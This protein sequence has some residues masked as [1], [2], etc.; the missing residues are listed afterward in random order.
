MKYTFEEEDGTLSEIEYIQ[1]VISEKEQNDLKYWLNSMDDFKSGS[2]HFGRI[3]REQKWYGPKYFNPT[4]KEKFDRWMP[5]EYDEVLLELQERVGRIMGTSCNSCLINK[6]IS[7]SS[8]IKLHKD[9]LN[10]F[11]ETPIIMNISLGSSRNIRFVRTKPNSMKWDKENKMDFQ[12]TLDSGSLL[13]M[14][15][16]TQKYFVHGIPKTKE[17]V[18]TRY[19]L[20]FRDYIL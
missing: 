14:K 12:I 15:G 5:C 17:H 9:D 3:P 6:Y 2:T 7:G 10:S 11:G 13:I 18:G 4:W 1:N 20:T 19:S 8:S 16:S